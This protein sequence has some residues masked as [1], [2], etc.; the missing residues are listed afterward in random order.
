[1]IIKLLEILDGKDHPF[2]NIIGRQVLNKLWDFVDAHPS[3]KIFEVSLE[4][5]VATDS[6]F[7]RESVVALAKQF[8]GEKWFFISNM[9][10]EDMFDNWDYGAKAKKQSLLVVF[11]DGTRVIGPDLKS[12]T[13]ELL[14]YVLKQGE[15]STAVVAKGLDISVQNASTRL[16]KLASEGLILRTE[17]SSKTGGI[18]YLYTTPNKKS[19]LN[20][21]F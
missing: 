13:V 8:R 11:S 12:S 2:G 6:S 3:E 9:G 14:N 17:E 5:I 18:E 4:G 21:L 16:K 19:C 7:P 1:M 20:R 15:V 10:T